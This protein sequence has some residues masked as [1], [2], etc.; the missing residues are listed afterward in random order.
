MI[1]RLPYVQGSSNFIGV[2]VQLTHIASPFDGY[3]FN[4]VMHKEIIFQ[5]LVVQSI[6]SLTSSLVVK[7]LTVLVSTISNSQVFFAEKM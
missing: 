2:V 5:G 7:M 6:I 4:K 3:Y 1:S